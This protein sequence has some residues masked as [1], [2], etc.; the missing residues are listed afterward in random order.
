MA[1][2]RNHTPPAV[3]VVRIIAGFVSLIAAA[4]TVVA[5]NT[6]LDALMVLLYPLFPGLIAGILITGGHGGS[7]AQETVAKIVAPEVNA[8]FY[9]LL[10]LTAHKIWR[11]LLSRPNAY[12]QTPKQHEAKQ[13]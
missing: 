7:N 9:A 13:P 5:Q 11:A 10:I 12:R 3:I 2:I 8:A 4:L 1:I 6:N